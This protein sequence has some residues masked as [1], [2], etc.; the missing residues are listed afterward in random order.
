M[1]QLGRIEQWNDDKGYGFVRP[2]ESQAGADAP[3]AF[4]HIKAIERAGRRP[5]EGDLVRYE[6]QRDAKG[7]LSAVGVAFVNASLMRARAQA[8]RDA[9][10]AVR[11]RRAAS[12]RQVAGF[13]RALATAA[14]VVLLGGTWPGWWPALVLGVYLVMSLVTYFVYR[15]DKVRAE[16]GR[17]RTPE[18]TLHTLDL[19][20]GWPGGL[21]AQQAFRHKSS[22]GSFQVV[23]WLTVLLNCAALAW[24]SRTG[25]LETL[26]R[27]LLSP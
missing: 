11:E 2:L 16:R 4:V 14:A 19:L 12:G 27:S 25:T 9:K 5:A 15:D 10:T 23:F 3:R 18:K 6:V 1:S 7:R 17:R 22:K 26:Q 20:G 21:L 13:R 8:A 24:L